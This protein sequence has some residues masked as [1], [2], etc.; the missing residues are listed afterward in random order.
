MDKNSACVKAFKNDIRLSNYE[1]QLE[2][3]VEWNVE[4]DVWTLV[5]VS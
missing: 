3:Q 5:C 4:D 1:K 2:T